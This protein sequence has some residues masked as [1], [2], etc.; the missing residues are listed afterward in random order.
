MSPTACASSARSCRC[1]PR[2]FGARVR[3]EPLGQR[4]GGGAQL[5]EPAGAEVDR[6]EDQHVARDVLR[7][8]LQE[9]QLR[10]EAGDAAELDLGVGIDAHMARRRGDGGAVAADLI[11]EHAGTGYGH[12]PDETL[13]RAARR[14]RRRVRQ[15]HRRRPLAGARTR[16]RSR[17]T[18]RPTPSTRRSTW[19]RERADPRSPA[20]GR[21]RSSSSRSG[22]VDVG[23][24]RHPRPRDRARGGHGRGRG[25]RAGGQAAGGADRAARRRAARAI[26]RGAPSASPGC[27]RTRRSCARSSSTT[28]AT[29]TRSG[30]SRSAS[31]RSAGC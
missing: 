24:A 5:L 1:L 3:G 20:P 30:R 17:S 11:R 7:R 8:A 25:R 2:A 9:V 6:V 13:G 21:T 22:K 31:T 26:W 15:R 4:V 18:S 12:G 23:R 27:R 19:P 16:R 28:A 10:V 29:S 14:A